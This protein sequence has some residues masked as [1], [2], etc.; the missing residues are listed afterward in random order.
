MSIQST[1]QHGNLGVAQLLRHALR[2]GGGA[3]VIWHCNGVRSRAT[4]QDCAVRAARLGASLT[5]R[6]VGPGDVVATFG[7]ADVEHFEAYL[8]VPARGMILHPLNIRMHDTDLA[9][10]LQ[11]TGDCV[12]IVSRGYFERFEQLAPMLAGTRLRLVLV[13]GQEPVV[14]AKGLPVET[15]SY[16]NFLADAPAMR[17]D[18]LTD[19]EETAAAT[20]CHTGGTTGRPKSVVYSH[21]SIWL[22]AQSLTSANSLGL[23]R[24]D[25]LLPA[26]PF[27]HVNGWGMPFAAVMAGTDLV[28]PGAEFRPDALDALIEDCGVTIAAG[29]PTIWSDLLRM[30]DATGATGF[31]TLSRLATGGSVVPKS[32]IDAMAEKKVEIIQ[33]WGMTET[34]S[35]SVLGRVTHD[36]TD[37]GPNAQQPIGYP[38]PGLELRVVAADGETVEPGS[39]TAGE[40]QIRGPCVTRSYL[41]TDADDA[42]DG[43]WL[44]TGDI[45]TIDALGR[46][47]LTDRLKDAI[48]SGGEW[49]AAPVLEDALRGLPGILDAAVIAMPHPRFQERPLAVVVCE[50]DKPAD[51]AA[52]RDRLRALVPSWWLPDGWAVVPSLP[53]TGLGK[54]DKAALRCLHVAGALNVVRD[55]AKTIPSHAKKQPEKT[56]E[57]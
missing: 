10:S 27:Y 44:R 16:G 19:P 35:M 43:G 53:R 5:A 32:L 21:R 31:K 22:Q 55:S 33:A 4:L 14:S 1:M 6:G 39:G 51:I 17:A 28:L 12:I 50:A 20:I 57:N 7:N 29:V 2:F 13:T 37:V 38:M 56:N 49:I 36:E 30:R 11:E 42:F 18:A 9:N 47:T 52:H 8:G 24:R 15:L 45:G 23:S 26:V 3:D 25:T 34:S 40:I 41:G 48:K 54:P 46:L